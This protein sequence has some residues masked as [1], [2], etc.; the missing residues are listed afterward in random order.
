MQQVYITG[1]MT[2]EAVNSFLE[3]DRVYEVNPLT[4]G[5]YEAGMPMRLQILC[6]PSLYGFISQSMGIETE[7]LIYGLIPGIVLLGSY[8]A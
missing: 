1:D 5:A 7:L 4:G 2:L 8:L 3:S 6:L